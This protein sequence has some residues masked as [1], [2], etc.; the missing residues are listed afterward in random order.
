MNGRQA[1]K[2]ASLQ[3]IELERIRA[4]NT[5]DIIDYNLCILSMIDGRSP[6]PFC[7]DYDECQLEAKDH[8]GCGEW[9]VRSHEKRIATAAQAAEEAGDPDGEQGSE[10]GIDS[11]Q[12]VEEQ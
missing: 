11:V 1:A 3:V 5:E 7:E 4:L 10:T 2:L 6:C 9:M 12:R 8:K